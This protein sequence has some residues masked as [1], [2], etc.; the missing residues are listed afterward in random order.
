MDS[1]NYLIRFDILYVLYINMKSQNYNTLLDFARRVEKMVLNNECSKAEDNDDVFKGFAHNMMAFIDKENLINKMKTFVETQQKKC[2]KGGS[3]EHDLCMICMDDSP[4]MSTRGNSPISHTVLDREPECQFKLHQRCW[5]AIRMRAGG[6]IFKCP[7][8]NR[9]LIM[10]G[11]NSRPQQVN[12]D[13]ENYDNNYED[14]DGDDDEDIDHVVNNEL[15][16]LHQ[17]DNS[18]DIEIEIMLYSYIVG[19]LRL[20]HAVNNNRI[21]YNFIVVAKLYFNV[22]MGNE[23]TIFNANTTNRATLKIY[24]QRLLAV[25]AI[26]A[27]F[28][29]FQSLLQES[30]DANDQT[31]LNSIRTSIANSDFPDIADR[32]LLFWINFIPIRGGKMKKK[33]T[34]R[35]TI[36]KKTTKKKTL[37]RKISRKSN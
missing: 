10:R 15:D 6:F 12:P 30:N 2:T 8:C 21:V 37:K 13:N 24:I 19:L 18:F 23:L 29:V 31:I 9:E 22:Y 27:C 5:N 33:S 26:I 7:M 25:S 34:K 17:S 35:K 14:D 32:F 11:R 20:L 16:N 28:Q 3:N 4:G 1:K 36:K